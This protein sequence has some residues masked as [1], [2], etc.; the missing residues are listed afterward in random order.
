MRPFKYGILLQNF[1][2]ENGAMGPQK[3]TSL[4]P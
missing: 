4:M 3:F 1:E 2:F